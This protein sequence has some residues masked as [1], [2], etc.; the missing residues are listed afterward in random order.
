MG[1][2]DS[3]ACGSKHYPTPDMD[4]FVIRKPA[5]CVPLHVHSHYSFLDST[6]SPEAVVAL[7]KERGLPAVA[8][9]DPNLH[10][11]VEFCALAKLAG[12][13][14]VVG[15]ELTVDGQALWRYVQNHTGY[16]NLCR[17]LSD[18][19]K[20][21]E[22][23]TDG[24]LAVGTDDCWAAHFPDRFYR[25]ITDPTQPVRSAFPC[26]PHLPVHHAVTSDL[27]L[28]VGQSADLHDRLT[29]YRHVHPDRDSIKTIRLVHLVRRIE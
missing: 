9:T 6:L 25:A 4:R 19:V 17:L 29:S 10:G 12:I 5:T 27:L 22:G 28:Y 16:A 3:G 13:Q 24:L 18:P 8:V 14:P 1:W 15:A 7:A 26:V 2:L 11:A 23:L 20:R 21:L